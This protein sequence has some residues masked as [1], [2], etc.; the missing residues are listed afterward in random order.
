MYNVRIGLRL[1]ALVAATTLLAQ[2][3]RLEGEIDV[4]VRD[5]TGAPLAARVKLTGRAS[6]QVFE[7]DTDSEGRWRARRLPF[8]PYLITVSHESFAVATREIEIRSEIPQLR[9][10]TL[11]LQPIETSVHVLDSV[12]L[13]DPGQ[14][15]TVFR[16]DR[17]RL[18]ETPFSA[19]G[20]GATD[21]LNT[22][23]GWLMEANSV[24]HPRGSEY[25]TQYV[26]DGMPLTDNRSPAFA[27]A[28]ETE[29]VTTKPKVA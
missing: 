2:A 10:I 22:L 3:H 21:I 13:I 14:A 26:I 20:H 5:P 18:E 12:T 4:V 24:L 29:D 23:P 15:G 19:P 27:P 6:G 8:G 1:A 28:I 9:E 16:V 17:E 25:D 7:S 11:S